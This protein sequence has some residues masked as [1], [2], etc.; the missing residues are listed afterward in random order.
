LLDQG[1]TPIRPVNPIMF[2]G[3]KVFASPTT[4][5]CKNGSE[6]KVQS[7][8]TV[9]LRNNSSITAQSGSTITVYSDANITVESGS[10]LQIKAGANLNLIGGA[11]I[12]IKSGGYICVES[13]ANIN[14]QDYN[15]VIALEEGAI[16]GANPSLFNSPSCLGTII[17]TGSGS[18]IDYSQD[19]YIQNETISANRYIAGKSVYVGNHVTSSKPQ[20]DVVINNGSNIIFDCKD[21]TFESGFECV[22]GSTYEVINH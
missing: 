15:T 6:I 10:T 7:A 3:N 18:I 16:Y 5:N 11:K 2:N 22:A 8:G 1:L 4:F 19:V 20:G 12:V 14:L 21:I 13:G 17:K 9:V